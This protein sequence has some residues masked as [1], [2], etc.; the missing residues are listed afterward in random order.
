MPLWSVGE[1]SQPAWLYKQAPSRIARHQQLNDLVTRA[2]V[3][4]G[5]PATKEPV[6]LTRRDGKRPDG[7]TLIPWRS[8]KL[9]IW[10]VTVV[11][12]LADSYVATA[13]REREEVA[14]LAP[15]R[16]CQNTR[17]PFSIHFPSNCH[18][19]L[20]GTISKVSGDSRERSFIF[21][22]PSITIQRFNAA[23]FHESF[24][25]HD[26]PDL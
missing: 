6:G 26:D 23:L 10:E 2:L 13:A 22:R 24:T 16:K 4:A 1:C 25:R 15:A 20:G 9:S 3:S 19:D 8:W 17:N 7:T 18:G 11:S 12:T 21:Q 14:E 5:V